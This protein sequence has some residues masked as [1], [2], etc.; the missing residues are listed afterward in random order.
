MKVVSLNIER[1]KH[2]D[3][4]KNF[5]AKENPEII[6]LM[7]V[8]QSDV[9]ILAGEDYPYRIYAPNAVM[10]E[11][12]GKGTTGVAILS[13]E[14]M[15]D[16][17]VFYCGEDPDSLLEPVGAGYTHLPVLILAN[18]GDLQIGAIHFTWT[19][20]GSIDDQQRRNMEIL[21]DYLSTK[22]E[23]VICGD[24]NIPRGNEMYK[25]LL[26]NYRDNVPAEIDTTL[27]PNLHRANFEIS[28]KLKYVVDY[29]WSTPKYTVSEVR[30]E[31]GVSDHCG[32][33]FK[34]SVI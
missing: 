16:Y 34:I 5:L 20:D 9:A 3:L 26:T 25:K 15:D 33:V 31:Q 11:S 24:F 30:V 10:P 19:P 1:H 7:E 27:D 32:I 29:I 23:L 22:D 14:M 21:L 12:E 4:V 2:F 8:C 6:C 18:L 13:K 17:E 28:G